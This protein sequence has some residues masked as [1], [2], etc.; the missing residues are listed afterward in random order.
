MILHKKAFCLNRN[1]RTCKT[2]HRKLLG[3]L[4]PSKL[5][6]AE[7]GT[8]LQ[9]TGRKVPNIAAGET[10]ENDLAFHWSLCNGRQG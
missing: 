8:H 7:I 5:K 9:C 2:A 3:F 10:T 6:L 4:P 1:E